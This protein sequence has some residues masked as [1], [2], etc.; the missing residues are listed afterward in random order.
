MAHRSRQHRSPLDSHRLDFTFRGEGV[1]SPWG[2]LPTHAVLRRRDYDRSLVFDP[3][4]GEFSAYL[5]SR[6]SG[7]R[8]IRHFRRRGL[9]TAAQAHFATRSLERSNLS[10]DPSA[11]VRRFFRDLRLNELF[12]DDG[13][14]GL[15]AVEPV[16]ALAS[17]THP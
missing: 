16:D 9:I 2:D 17:E 15:G 10:E 3:R 1:A 4:Q 5:F 14:L 6:K 12:A 7:M 13:T 8:Q 11:T